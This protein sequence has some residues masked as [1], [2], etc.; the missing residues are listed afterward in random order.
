MLCDAEMWGD[1]G[2]AVWLN[3]DRDLGRSDFLFV[4]I[5]DFE[6]LGAVCA[7]AR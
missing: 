1:F 4:V 5:A 6:N 2:V 7:T 3:A